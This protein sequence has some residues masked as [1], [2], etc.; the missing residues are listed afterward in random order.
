MKR[1]GL[2]RGKTVLASAN[3]VVAGHIPW[4]GLS[5]K[6]FPHLLSFRDLYILLTSLHRHIPLGP[7]LHPLGPRRV[8][9]TCRDG[10][11]RGGKA[12][13]YRP[14]PPRPTPARYLSRTAIH[15]IDQQR[16]FI[17]SPN[18]NQSIY[19]MHPNINVVFL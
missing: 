9:S 16:P 2:R 19:S 15:I 11:G 3:E 18:A 6:P 10:S 5:F 17:S 13:P 8:G 7:L 12:F 1:L 4:G 14:A